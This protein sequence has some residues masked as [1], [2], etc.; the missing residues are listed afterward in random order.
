MS[1]E[2]G[3]RES[4]RRE[5]LRKAAFVAPAVLTL[6]AAPSFASAGSDGGHER[7]RGRNGGNGW[8]GHDRYDGRRGGRDRRGRRGRDDD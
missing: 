7:D 1:E 8:D 4:T 2:L 6:A 5:I 3:P